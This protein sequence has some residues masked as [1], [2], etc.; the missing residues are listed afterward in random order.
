MSMAGAYGKT[1]WCTFLFPRRASGTTY[2][3]PTRLCCSSKLPRRSTAGQSAIA[4]HAATHNP[5]NV[6]TNW[7]PVGTDTI[8]TRIGTN[9]PQ[10]KHVTSSPGCSSGARFGIFPPQ[11]RGS[12]FAYCFD[13]LNDRTRQTAEEER[14]QGH[15]IEIV[16]TRVFVAGPGGGNP[17]PVVLAADHLKGRQMQYLSEK[18]GLDTVFILK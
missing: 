5:F 16:H 7:Q 12:K 8:S 4:S 11:T 18:F 1:C 2:S 9:G 6:C 17:C 15:V 3:T 10:R 13:L 14:R